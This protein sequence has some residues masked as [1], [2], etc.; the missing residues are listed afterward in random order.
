MDNQVKKQPVTI[1]IDCRLAGAKNAGIGRYIENMVL[2]LIKLK[3]LPATNHNQFNSHKKILWKLFFHDKQQTNAVFKNATAKD[4]FKLI[5][6]P[7]RHYTVA[8]QIIMPKVFNQE[9]LDLL[10]VPHF[11]IPLLYQGKLVVT[12]H[13]LLWHERGGLGATTLKPLQYHI[14]YKAYRLTTDLAVKK[15]QKIFVPAKTVANSIQ[16]FYPNYQP[17]VVVTY[18]GVGEAFAKSKLKI[19]QTNQEKKLVYTGSLYP[20]KNIAIVLKA[21]QALP[22]YQ[23]VLVGARN[24]FVEQTAKLVK[25]LKLEK[26]V[27][28]AGYLDD[29]QL[30]QLYLG[31]DA[32]VQ[33]SLSEGFGLTGV[34]AMAVGLPVICSDIAI[35]H[36]IYQEKAL[37]FNPHNSTSLIA[38][39]KK[40]TSL[41][42]N[43]S[44]QL[45]KFSQ[46]YQW[47]TMAKVICQHYAQLI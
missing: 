4:N 31:A 30:I 22:D 10:H 34:E 28:F 43:F 19:K 42:N 1:G 33:P 37:F 11:N 46:Q 2:E 24:I 41:P 13:D 15:A 7:V 45:I 36:E 27:S 17:K 35:F 26:Q 5:Y 21:L 39:I 44:Q 32:L 38:T 16:N 14:K 9:K 47:Q 20:H 23:L 18:E 25:Q 12:I 29:Q 40:L 3:T 8:E 6:C